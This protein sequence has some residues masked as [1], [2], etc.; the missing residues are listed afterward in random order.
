MYHPTSKLKKTPC[1]TFHSHSQITN[2]VLEKP[3]VAAYEDPDST[4]FLQ[5]A[6]DAEEQLEYYVK[7]LND[8]SIIG[9]RDRPQCSTNL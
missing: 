6:R 7:E 2:I 8:P 1:P 4:E 9:N 3:F 5:L